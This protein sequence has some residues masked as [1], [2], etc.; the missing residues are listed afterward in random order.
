[1]TNYNIPQIRHNF[2]KVLAKRLSSDDNS[3][4]ARQK[5][6]AD[7]IETIPSEFKSAFLVWMIEGAEIVK[8]EHEGAKQ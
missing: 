1:M 4:I 8:A 5:F 6:I 3:E 2:F 7:V